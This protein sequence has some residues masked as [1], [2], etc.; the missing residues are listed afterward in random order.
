MKNIF[1]L[2]KDLKTIKEIKDI[3]ILIREL[4]NEIPE[5]I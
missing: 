1:R 2:E 3:E 4:P 5:K